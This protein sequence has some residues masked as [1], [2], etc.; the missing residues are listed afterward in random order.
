MKRKSIVFTGIRQVEV[1]E[2]EWECAPLGRG[3]ALLETECTLISP[4][5]ELANLLGAQAMGKVAPFPK[6]LGYSAVARVLETGEECEFVPGDRVLIYHSKHRS[7]Q[8]KHQRDMVKIPEEVPS[9]DAVFCVTAAMGLQGLRKVQ[10]ELGESVAVV[11]LGL[12]GLAALRCAALNGAMPLIGIDFNPVRCEIAREFGADYTF[13]PDEPNLAEKIRELT[14][15]SGRGETI[16]GFPQGGCNGVLEVTGNPAAL[17]AALEYTAPFGRVALVGCS[18][19][20]TEQLDFYNKVHRPGISLI[21]AHNFARPQD[22][23]RAGFWTMRRDMSFLLRLIAQGRFVPSRMRN[24]VA[25]PEDAPSLY[26]RLLAHEPNLL[27]I[28]FDWTK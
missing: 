26:A 9:H 20:P 13:S 12:L 25:A 5:T 19:T 6:I 21:G 10:C 16:A 24:V 2:D 18:R 17:A 3:E 14:K 15:E 4:G 23:S 11:G 8:R 7:Y 22:N 1:L 28:V 27:G